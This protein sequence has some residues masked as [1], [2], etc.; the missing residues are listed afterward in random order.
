MAK[1]I[2]VPMDEIDRIIDE[3]KAQLLSGRCCGGAIEFKETFKKDDRVAHLYFSPTAWVKMSALVA[4]FYT[5]VQ[6]HGLVHRISENEFEVYDILVPPHTVSATTVISDQEEY[7][8]WL[9]DLDDETFNAMR[10][11]GHSHV[12][13]GVTPSGVDTG[14][15]SDL[16]TQLPR[17]SEDEDVF[18]IFLILN[19]S[20]SWSAEIYDISNNALYSS[21]DKEIDLAVIFEDYSFLDVFVKEAKKVAIPAPVAT[22]ATKAG[23]YASNNVIPSYEKGVKK[24]VNVENDDNYRDDYDPYYSRDAGGYA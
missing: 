9:N 1:T 5:E 19:K 4:D 23:Y 7:T 16:I 15:R 6:W 13:M 17:P 3:L 21:A 10:F 2:H 14:Y 12:N 20:H 22:A 11:H 8:N 18:Y 24:K